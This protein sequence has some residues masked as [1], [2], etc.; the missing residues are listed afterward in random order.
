MSK[1]VVSRALVSFLAPFAAA[2]CAVAL[3]GVAPSGATDK[4]VTPFLHKKSVESAHSQTSPA[5]RAAARMKTAAKA[6]TVMQI[7]PALLTPQPAPDC[8]Y[9]GTLSNPPTAEETRQKLDYEAQCYRQAEAVVRARLDALQE[10][11]REMMHRTAQRDTVVS[12]N[13]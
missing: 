4:P 9:K 10:A 3:V 13:K 5:P 2:C 6:P 11:V 7:D 1:P 8:A 12:I